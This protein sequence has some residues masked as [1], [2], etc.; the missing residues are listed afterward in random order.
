MIMVYQR[1]LRLPCDDIRSGLGFKSSLDAGLRQLMDVLFKAADGF[2]VEL[3]DD[4]GGHFWAIVRRGAHKIEVEGRY[5]QNSVLKD[6]E[7]ARFVS[8]TV[9][10][11]TKVGTSDRG[12][13]GG[14][15]FEVIGRIAGVVLSVAAVCGLMTTIEKTRVFFLLIPVFV[16]IVWAGKWLGARVGR[17]LANEIR[18]RASH[19]ALSGKDMSQ[20]DAIWKRLTSA[21]NTVTSGYPVA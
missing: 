1:I 4:T 15:N 7:K 10:A 8:Y 17:L 18:R 14:D 2:K 16:G 21:L 9:R 20:A 12:E 13:S 11:E 19:G 6:G 5:G 3:R